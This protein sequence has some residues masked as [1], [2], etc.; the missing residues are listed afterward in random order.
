[1]LVVQQNSSV[2]VE[3]NDGTVS[4]TYTV[5]GTDDNS[6]HHL[7][8]FDLTARNCF[9]DGY[10]DD[11][12]DAGVTAVRTAENLDAH[13]ATSAAVIGHIEHGLSLNHKISPTPSP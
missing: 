8:F 10:L 4:A 9:L 3:T 13:D 11:V 2:A 5:T 1:M 7:A 12:T 6:G